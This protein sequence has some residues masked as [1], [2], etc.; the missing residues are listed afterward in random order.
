MSRGNID[1]FVFI[2]HFLNDKWEPCH[3]TITFFEMANKF[4]N[5]MAIQVN[6]VLAKHG[7]NTHFLHMSKM[8]GAI[9]P[10]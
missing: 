10:P 7:L 8:K 9:L 6:D 2:V 4:G 5:A 1:T 3:V